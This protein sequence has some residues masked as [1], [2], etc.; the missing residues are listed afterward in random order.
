MN[1]HLTA[2]LR[3]FPA[4]I[5][6]AAAGLIAGVLV[7]ACGPGHAVASA[8]ASAAGAS[9]RAEA[10]SAAGQ[11]AKAQ[12][13]S[14]ADDCKPAGT[15]FDALEPG[16]PGA[17]AARKTFESCE[18][19]PR[20]ALFALGVCLT[21]AY[22]HAPAKGAQASPAETARQAYLAGA[23]GACVQAAKGRQPAGSPSAAAST[24][25]FT[26]SSSVSRS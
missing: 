19:I 3:R 25:T 20:S 8:G 23:E 22:S 11:A 6:P 7:A 16:V 26:P 5:A 4:V 13:I 2:R 18:K 14:V 24:A 9:A 17:P 10:S 1:N 21:R 15:G 12:A